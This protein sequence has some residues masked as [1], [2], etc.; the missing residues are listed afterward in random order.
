MTLPHD[1]DVIEIAGPGGPDVLKP[2]RRPVPPPGQ[3]QILIRIAFAGVN[4][5]DVLQRMGSYAPPPGASDLPG[6]ECS[7]H[8]AAIGPGVTR[9]QVGGGSVSG[10]R[11]SAPSPR[12]PRVGCVTERN[13]D[14]AL[15]V[16]CWSVVR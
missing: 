2:A 13:H 16:R 4:R 5:P 10:D 14:G 9:W 11:R 1:M 8:V 3:G 7:G 6:L 12:F 15:E